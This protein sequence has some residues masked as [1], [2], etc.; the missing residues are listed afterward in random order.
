MLRSLSV[1]GAIEHFHP[2]QPYWYIS[3]LA[4]AESARGKGLGGKILQPFLAEVDQ[5]H[6]AVYL[7]SSNPKNHSF[8]QR[9]GFQVLKEFHYSAET[10]PIFCMLRAPR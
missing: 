8:Y 4:V 10:P 5:R 1:L 7:E 6:E 2:Q 9:H 3:M